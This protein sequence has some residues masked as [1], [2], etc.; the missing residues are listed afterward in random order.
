MS[1]L[2][3]KTIVIIGGTSGFG[4]SGALACQRAGAN[5]VV[6]GRD[7]EHLDAA[8]AAL[9]D[10]TV[11]LT[12][13]ACSPDAAVRAVDH[14]AGTF[15]ACEALYHVAGG[16]GR[17]FGDGPAHEITDE[18]W[19]RTIALNQTSTFYS[20]RAA[21][22]HWQATGKPGV[23]LNMSSVLAFSPAPAHFA[24]HAYATAKAAVIGL[25]Q[26][27]AAHYAPFGIRANALAPAC[28]D[29]PM[30]ARAREDARIQDFLKRKQPLDGGRMGQTSDVD[31]AA[32]FLLSDAS[33]Y[34]TGQVLA[35]DGG[36]SVTDA[37]Y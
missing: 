17:V 27:I 15:G 30:A 6:L 28:T 10:S 23:L 25:T 11:I 26:A 9:G 31:G 33:A 4:L 18:G 19:A 29:T 36:W 32:V 20:N 37:G 14:A 1:E 5:L 2:N 24:T 3:G 22:A 12:G 34:I 13:D 21:L 7:D 35:V 8:R 16:S